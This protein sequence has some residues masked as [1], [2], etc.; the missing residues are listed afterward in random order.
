MTENWLD[1]AR[2]AQP[3]LVEHASWAEANGRLHDTALRALVEAGV[4]RLYLPTRL[5]GGAVAPA[6][7]AQVC[8]ILAMA[9]S[10]AGW[11]VMVYN[12]ARMMASTWPAALV[13]RLWGEAPDAM[14]AA[15]GHT[16]LEGR[17]D[18]DMVVVSGRNSFVSGC[19][20]AD[21][22]MSPVLLDGEGFATVAVPAEHVTIV[23]NW[24]TVGMRGTGS[25]DVEIRAARIPAELVAVPGTARNEFYTDPLYRCPGRVVFATYIPVA[26]ALA[27]RALDELDALARAKVPYASDG[28]LRTRT[29]AQ[30]HYGR[31][32][33]KYRS[34]RTYFYDALDQ[35]WAQAQTGHEFTDAERADLYLAGTHTMQTCAEVVRHVADAAGS[36]SLYQSQ[37]LARIVR[38]MEALRHHGF[39]SESRFANVSQLLWE[40]ELDY[41]LLLR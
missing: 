7:C 1:R 4:P 17:R 38:D 30:S 9:D 31:A 10:A 23:D 29:L 19:H 8:E 24:D 33:G 37:P 18:G 34:T 39:A 16:P 40:A 14:V 3:A 36:S 2:A 12:A 28:K 5:G 6:T 20:H 32:L 13:Q 15:S 11:H 21:Y 26:L 41:P 25:N 22:V 27:A 35:V